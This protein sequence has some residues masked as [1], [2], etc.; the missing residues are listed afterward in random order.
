MSDTARIDK[1]LWA[2]RAYKTR[3]DAT[4]ACKGNKVQVNGVNAKPSKMLKAG[5][6]ISVRK[7]AVLYSYKVLR[8]LENRVGVQLV[9][10]YA[11]NLTPQSELDKARAPKETFF[12]RRERGSG[13]PTKKERREIDALAANLTFE[14]AY[15]LDGE[16]GLDADFGGDEGDYEDE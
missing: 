16:V 2:I 8:L 3:S 4:D 13:R 1:Y 6:R 14:P 5:D 7:G 15:G 12:V 10:D 11:E 9:G